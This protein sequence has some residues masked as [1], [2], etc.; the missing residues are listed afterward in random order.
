MSGLQSMV[1]LL[2]GLR[3]P[4]CGLGIANQVG[5]RISGRL[6]QSDQPPLRCHHRV[7]LPAVMSGDE[8]HR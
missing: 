8:S 3:C 7:L 6:L 5:F 4:E 1:S 2:E